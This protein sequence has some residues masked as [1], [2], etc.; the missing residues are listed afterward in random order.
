MVAD[1]QVVVLTVN[2][3]G[4]SGVWIGRGLQ[5]RYGRPRAAI[6]FDCGWTGRVPS[7]DVSL[8]KALAHD[9]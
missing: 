3:K 4:L 6:C 5:A 8:R 9:C 7:S 1:L 2:P